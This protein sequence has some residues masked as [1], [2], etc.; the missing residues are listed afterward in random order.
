RRETWLVRRGDI[1]LKSGRTSEAVAAYRAALAAIE[2]LPPRY[3]ETVPVEK[4]ERD[5]RASLGQISSR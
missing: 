5:A 3:R 4:L 2:E 1:L